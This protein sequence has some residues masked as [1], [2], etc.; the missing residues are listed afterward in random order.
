MG[1]LV[2]PGFQ[3][4]H[5]EKAES[6]QDHSRPANLFTRSPRH[7]RLPM[8]RRQFLVAVALFASGFSAAL[9]TRGTPQRA[10]APVS[11]TVSTIYVRCPGEEPWVVHKFTADS[12]S[13]PG[14]VAAWWVGPD[15]RVVR[16]GY[17]KAGT[18]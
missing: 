3:L 2:E 4:E 16:L 5:F 7:Y 10:S 14:D 13:K 15:G 18:D 17:A 8:N 6:L 1:A 12:P 9:V 11:P